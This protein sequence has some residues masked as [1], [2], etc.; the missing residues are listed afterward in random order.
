MQV[1]ERDI[2]VLFEGIEHAIAV[3]GVDV[4]ISDALQPVPGPQ[5][6]DGDTAII[7]GAETCGPLTACV[8]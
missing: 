1:D 2:G 5:P 7:Q 8:M 6:L 4:H 3:V